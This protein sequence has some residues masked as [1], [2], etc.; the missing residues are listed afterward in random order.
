MRWLRAFG[1]F[2][3]DLVFGDDWRIAVGVAVALAGTWAV[4][5]TDDQGW[6][7]MPLAVLVI[8]PVSIWQLVRRNR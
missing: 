8:L 4:A 2:W 1:R 7:V 6:W 5:R 3:Y